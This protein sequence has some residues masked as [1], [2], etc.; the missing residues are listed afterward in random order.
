MQANARRDKEAYAHCASLKVHG[1]VWEDWPVSSEQWLSIYLMWTPGQALPC[2]ITH[3]S[4]TKCSV[5]YSY[6][7]M[8][9]HIDDHVIVALCC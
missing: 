1:L 8:I 7:F 6:V 5:G 2:L 9:S 4:A 3:L